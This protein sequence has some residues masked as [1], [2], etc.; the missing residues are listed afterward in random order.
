MT[1]ALHPLLLIVDASSRADLQLAPRVVQVD[2]V[3]KNPTCLLSAQHDLTRKTRRAGCLEQVSVPVH[4]SACKCCRL[5]KLRDR[6]GRGRPK[7]GKMPS[8]RPDVST[9]ITQV[10]TSRRANL[11]TAAIDFNTIVRILCQPFKSIAHFTTYGKSELEGASMYSG[12]QSCRKGC[13]K[14]HEPQRI[15][16]QCPLSSSP[17][18]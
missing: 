5:E 10:K 7:L 12:R 14:N 18:R 15:R 11:D 17:L 6:H 3:E 8:R 9:D 1:T 4:R 16:S 13:K 2:R